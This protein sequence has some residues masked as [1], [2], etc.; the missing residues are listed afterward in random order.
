MCP[1]NVI[2][3]IL[4]YIYKI[5][6]QQSNISAAIKIYNLLIPELIQYSYKFAHEDR[7][8][9]NIH[10]NDTFHNLTSPAL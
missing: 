4:R 7:H 5:R 9:Y 10:L 1:L 8:K 6:F 2:Y 3:E